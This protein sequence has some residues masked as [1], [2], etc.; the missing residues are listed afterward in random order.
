M[1]Q[2]KFNGEHVFRVGQKIAHEFKPIKPTQ[3]EDK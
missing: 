1:T 3:K 2:L